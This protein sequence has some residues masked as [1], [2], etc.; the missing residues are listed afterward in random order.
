MSKKLVAYFSASGTTKEAA[1]RLAKVAG[2]DLFEIRPVVPYSKAD[3]NWM[4]KNSRSSVEMNDP[5]SRPEIAETIPN[6]A[7]YDTVFIGFPIWWYVAP[8]I[9][10]TFVESYDFSGKTLVPFATSGGSGMGR[11]VDELKKLCPN[12]DWKAGKM[13]SGVSDQAL[14]A[15]A[16]EFS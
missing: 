13:M 10:H 16:A 8:H 3:L 5:D 1:E 2:A 11:T 4:D 14:A 9:I 12:A 7:D 15:W 6:M